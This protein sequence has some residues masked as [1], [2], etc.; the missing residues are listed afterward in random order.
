MLSLSLE[1]I[2]AA[3]VAGIACIVHQRGF[4]EV[5]RLPRLLS[6]YVDALICNSD[7]VKESCER[8]GLP[9]KQVVRV[10]NGIDLSQAQPNVPVNQMRHALGFHNASPVVG[11]VGTVQ[12]WKGQREVIL[13]V[14]KL[15]ELFP[16]IHCLIAGGVYDPIYGAEI[17]ELTETLGLERNVHFLGHRKDIVDLMNAMDIIIHASIDPEP[18]GK[19]LIEAMAL[20][21][22]LIA[23]RA[24]G[25]LEIVEDHVT[26]LLVPPGDV[27]AMAKAVSL[28]LRNR[29]LAA[30]MGQ[31]GRQRVE[32]LFELRK[33]VQ[34]IEQIYDTVQ[35]A[36]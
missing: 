29:A 35:L 34:S 1:G 16:D 15:R 5:Y 11:I 27:D 7:A 8:E 22:P 32:K 9:I 13:A 33:T 14:D 28:L 18:F 6:G 3:K 20:G 26:G 10:Y 36:S 31:A 25:P 23:T 19:V 24:G 21:K 30:K 17:K 2:L 12:R 4:L